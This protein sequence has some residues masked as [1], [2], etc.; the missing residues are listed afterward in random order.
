MIIQKIKIK[1]FGVYYGINDIIL[2]TDEG[3]NICLI[4]GNNGY[5]KTTLHKAVWYAFYGIKE[6]YRE[7]IDFMNKYALMNGELNTLVEIHFI[8]NGRHYQITRSITAAAPNITKVNEVD[9]VVTLLEEGKPVKNI[10]NRI[11]DILPKEASQ[12]FFFDG[13]DIKRYAV[14][15][16]TEATKEAIEMVLG[17]PAIRNSINDLKI[18]KKE[19]IK[20][21]NQEIRKS[22]NLSQLVQ[23]SEEI[24]KEIERDERS[25]KFKNKKGKVLFP[26]I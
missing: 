9:E 13:E 14:L 1:N 7:R 3:K 11:N 6:K 25:G 2:P 20:K 18:I 4:D 19:L 24:S 12:F 15:E 5:G 21:R 10:E 26:R 8:H 16:N 17:V 22:K 23:Q